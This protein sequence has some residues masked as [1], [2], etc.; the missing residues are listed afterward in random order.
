M[1]NE[2]F[3]FSRN[4]NYCL[5]QVARAKMFHRRLCQ[6]LADDRECFSQT[7]RNYYYAFEPNVRLRLSQN[8]DNRQSFSVRHAYDAES[9]QHAPNRFRWFGSAWRADLAQERCARYRQRTKFHSAHCH[10]LSRSSANDFWK[11]GRIS[12]TPC[13]SAIFLCGRVCVAAANE[14][15]GSPTASAVLAWPPVRLGCQLVS[16]VSGILVWTAGRRGPFRSRR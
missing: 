8:S 13:R 16:R 4:T 9:G 2:D 6:Y 3:L 12:A 5:E 1:I 14:S 15:A 10:D 7:S 11:I